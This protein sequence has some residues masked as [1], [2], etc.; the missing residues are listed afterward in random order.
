VLAEPGTSFCTACGHALEVVVAKAPSLPGPPEERRSVSVLAVDLVGFSGTAQALEPEE[1]HAAQ[2][3]FFSVVATA[4]LNTGGVV[5]KRIGDA[6]VAVYGA[7]TAHENDP[8]R[9]VKAALE[10]QQA[11]AAHALPDGMPL[12]AR[13]G[14][15]TGEAI[16]G[17]DPES[18]VPRVAGDVLTR[19][20]SLQA[21]APPGGVLVGRQTYR[22]TA[23]RVLYAPREPI[24]LGADTEPQQVW[25]AQGFA[26]SVSRFDEVLPLVG[27]EPELGLLV[28]SVRRVMQERRGQLVTLIGEPGIGKSRLTRALF[29]H[30]DSPA[31]PTIVR[32]RVGQCLPYGEGVSYWALSQV[33]KTQASILESDSGAVARAKLDVS[34]DRVLPR[35]TGPEVVSQVKERLAALLG[36][37]GAGSDPT[38]DVDPSHAAWRRYLLALAED[39][40]TVLVIEDL[41]AA[42]DGFLTFLRTLVEAASS[43]PLLVLCTART[44]LMEGRSDWLAGLRDAMTITLTP[45]AEPEITAVLARLL[46]DAV[47]PEA[48]QRR[49]L[50]RVGGN[51]LYAEEYVRM[52]ADSGV[53]Q[54]T[55]ETEGFALGGS[56]D[57]LADLPL[58]DSVQGVV[59]SRLDLLTAAERSVVSAAA[60][61]GEV[62][63]EGAVAAV[64]DADRDE[65]L[66][67][68]EA[69]E[70]REVVRQSLSSSVGGE[71]E[72]AF[73]HVLVRD[74]A[75]SRIPRSLRVVQHRRCADWM[76]AFSRER[77]AD[78]SELRAHHRTTAYELAA[79]L[80]A[81]LE[82]YAAPARAALTAAAEHALRLHAVPA[83]HAFARRALMLWY[84][85]EDEPGALHATLMVASLAFLDDPHAFYTDGG[86]AKVEETARKL[87]AL[88]DRRGAARAEGILGQA[89]WYRGGV[90]GLA[91]KH[92]QRAV[93]LLAEEPADEQFATA[94]A[95]LGRY[96]MLN[97]QYADAIAL[98]DRAMAV[99]RP[100]GLL[101][102]EANALVTA[103][104]A[105]YSLGDPLGIVQ[106]EEGLRLSRQHGLRALQRAANNLA[107]TMQEEGRLRR[108]YELIEES[109]R[110]T[111]GWGLSLTTR[112]DD[113]EIALM[114]WYDGDWDRLLTH[115][116]AFLAGAGE[117]AQQWETHLIALACI[118]HSLRG[119]PIP[120]ELEVVVER[121]RR[122][123]FPAIARSSL[124]LMGCARYLEGNTAESEKLFDELLGHTTQSIGGNVREWA[125]SAVLLAS[126]LGGGRLET[127]SA[128]LAS[129]KPKTPWIV[130][131]HQIALSFQSTEE[132]KLHDALEHAS[133][134]VAL[135]ERIG[136]ASTTTFARIRLARTAAACGDVVRV[137]EQAE[138]VRD[139]VSRNKAR[140]LLD[141]LP[142]DA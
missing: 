60:V 89:E 15:S 87:L 46:G 127:I 2:R 67:C 121:S 9:A 13:A 100:L 90:P 91:A 43:T 70:R 11:L 38:D 44:E 134:A 97:H 1:L 8:E 86:P 94:L 59:D 104:T 62:F 61:V 140:V 119:E 47:L 5:A 84:G 10:T 25:L 27:R 85:H 48:L 109:A 102:V 113:S 32:W 131:A 112:A 12:V 30:I 78:L 83:A 24:R 120:P 55:G 19:A 64:A 14:V 96:W 93:D 142:D 141:Y 40:P 28:S 73:R 116:D 3:S 58:P 132:G 23:P 105:R 130:A 101:E 124:V 88:G 71:H 111:R 110:A 77:G 56:I 41:H 128:R 34:V 103:G 26:A 98:S 133:E 68:L 129:L 20:M 49:M 45:L 108:S 118:V 75:Y 76:E 82:P 33:V 54:R 137:R 115:T 122:S 138:L 16:V 22:M 39:T 72:F 107:A 81:D 52:L 42:D 65:V 35:T 17:F 4:V 63:W 57:V 31:T 92:L 29:D 106:Q 135:Y 53:I 36:L 80:G 66:R 74:A 7:P 79:V 6:V 95:E 123:A 117:E 126:L 136:D 114:A 18:E 99:A 139:F 50:D 21:A 125:Y 37:P 51:P 69:L